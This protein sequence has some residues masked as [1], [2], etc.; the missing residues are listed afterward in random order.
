M[1]I[2][3]AP[4]MALEIPGDRHLGRG[5]GIQPPNLARKFM[6]LWIFSRGMLDPLSKG[7]YIT[8]P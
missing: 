7:G 1:L 6:K 5:F 4:A 2:G 3:A 8:R